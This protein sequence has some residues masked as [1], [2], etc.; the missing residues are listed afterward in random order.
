M[1]EAVLDVRVGLLRTQQFYHRAAHLVETVQLAEHRD[2]E[3]A[4][5]RP[6]AHE[7]FRPRRVHRRPLLGVVRMIVDRLLDDD[8]GVPRVLGERE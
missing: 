2:S 5:L 7:A 6:E 3:E 4:P 1:V 8:S